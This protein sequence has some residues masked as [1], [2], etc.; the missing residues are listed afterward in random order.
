[1]TELD[2]IKL[3]SGITEAFEDRRLEEK[4][5]LA[6][7]TVRNWKNATVVKT[8]GGWK[9]LRPAQAQLRKSSPRSTV[10]EAKKKKT[11]GE[12]EHDCGCSGEHDSCECELDERGGAMDTWGGK[13]DNTKFGS[14]RPAGAPKKCPDG[15][16]WN[17][18]SQ[19]CVA[20]RGAPANG[21]AMQMYRAAARTKLKEEM[22]ALLDE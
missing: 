20:L 13:D 6:V 7:G 10:V 1:M 11:K 2:R 14:T 16:L 3:L 15:Q 8:A 22:S 17:N 19:K 9:T 12:D 18:Q 4:R 21:R 5:G